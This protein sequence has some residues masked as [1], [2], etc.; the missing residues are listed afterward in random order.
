MICIRIM[1]FLCVKSNALA[2]D[3]VKIVQQGFG[4][5]HSDPKARCLIIIRCRLGSNLYP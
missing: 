4:Q 5:S 2:T 1:A 3:N